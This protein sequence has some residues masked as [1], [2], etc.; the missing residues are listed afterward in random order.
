METFA[1]HFKN[2]GKFSPTVLC[3]NGKLNPM[4]G[5]LPI[6]TGQEAAL[7]CQTHTRTRVHTL[8]YTHIH[9]VLERSRSTAKVPIPL[10]S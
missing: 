5:N 2:E 10:D 8:T 1:W 7:F 6:S 3:D 4:W 9:W